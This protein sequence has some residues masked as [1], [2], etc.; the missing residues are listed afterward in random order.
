MRGLRFGSTT[1][2]SCAALGY[3]ALGCST[4]QAAEESRPERKKL[5]E[6]VVTGTRQ[7]EQLRDFAGSISVVK[8]DDVTVV[9]STHHSE[10]INR[11]PG[12]MI[13]R[14]SGE[15]SLTAIRSPVLSGPGSCGVFLFLENSVPIRPTGFCNVNE[16]FEVNTEQAGSIEVL[17]GPAGVIYGSGAMH[18]AVNV[19]T[20]EPG[21]LPARSLA[22]EGGPDE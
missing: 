19:I 16:L 21:D 15:E 6:V 20:T 9:G 13:Q 12:A 5:E 1:L 18:G 7:A 22:I 2:L 8:S 17:R 10:I 11:V 14:N 3:T 4:V